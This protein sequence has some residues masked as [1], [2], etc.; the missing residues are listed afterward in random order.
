MSFYVASRFS[1]ELLDSSVLSVNINRF[2]NGTGSDLSSLRADDVLFD[3]GKA[4]LLAG[5][6]PS[7]LANDHPEL[8][9]VPSIFFAKF[10]PGDEILLVPE[11]K[12]AFCDGMGAC[13]CP[14]ILSL[15]STTASYRERVEKTDEGWMWREA[16][17][18]NVEEDKSLHESEAACEEVVNSPAEDD[19]GGRERNELETSEAAE[20]EE[21]PPTETVKPRDVTVDDK[22]FIFT[23]CDES[24]RFEYVIAADPI[25]A[26]KMAA[27]QFDEK[28][29]IDSLE[30]CTYFKENATEAVWYLS[31]VNALRTGV[32]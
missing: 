18:P 20:V 26:S 1:A 17:L 4:K 13:N 30:A 12:W 32:I 5:S 29:F 31:R 19:L 11:G 10:L 14:T 24:D 16:R 22:V 27:D 9:D 8:K 23:T 25:E 28:V 15:A 6:G 21:M 7:S 3:L 2:E